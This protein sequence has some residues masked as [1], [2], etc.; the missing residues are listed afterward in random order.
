MGVGTLWTDNGLQRN[1]CSY[2]TGSA[3]AREW[4]KYSGCDSVFNLVE[5]GGGAGTRCSHWSENC[6]GD[7]LMTGFLSGPFQPLSPITLAGL[8]DLGFPVDY[9]KADSFSSKDVSDSCKCDGRKLR[10]ETRAL[11]STRR[12]LSDEGQLAAERFG[13]LILGMRRATSAMFRH[14]D[15]IGM[16]AVDESSTLQQDVGGQVLI[17]L[18]EEDGDVYSVDVY[19]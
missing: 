10:G 9:S 2:R 4:K 18:Y 14:G 13:K 1:S 17:V 3:V 16:H 6:L 5:K 15:D 8:E 19:A 11:T 7:E 12:R